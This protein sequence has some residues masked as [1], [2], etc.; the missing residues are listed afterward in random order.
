MKVWGLTI[1]QC[2]YI[3]QG[4]SL[5]LENERYVGKAAAFR[6]LPFHSRAQY[7]RTSAGRPYCSPRRLR[8]TCYHGFRDFIL[9]CFARGATRVQ[10]VNGCWHSTRE[11]TL[12]LD[13]LRGLNMGAPAYPSYMSE[14]CDCD[15]DETAYP[16]DVVYPSGDGN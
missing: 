2:R 5:E 11:F 1:K 15:E 16:Y 14:L 9:T 6:V 3:A 4:L 8:A 12:D 7:S 10:S 13:R